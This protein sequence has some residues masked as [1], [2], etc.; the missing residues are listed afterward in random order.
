MLVENEAGVRY[1]LKRILRTHKWMEEDILQEARIFLLYSHEKYDPDR[2][3]S[4]LNYYSKILQY[5]MRRVA[6]GEARICRIKIGA[7]SR[8]LFS[9]IFSI[10]KKAF[11]EGDESECNRK[12]IAIEMGVDPEWVED[13]NVSIFLERMKYIENPDYQFN[14]EVVEEMADPTYLKELDHPECRLNSVESVK[15]M[16]EFA[17]SLKEKHADIF[18][19]RFMEDDP[20]TL[21]SIGDKYGISRE[22]VR[23]LEGKILVKF[24]E[25]CKEKEYI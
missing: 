23:Q 20:A 12:R 6:L 3:S 9:K 7:N 18:R 14:E 22:R 5:K 25:F 11:S 1:S 17:S 16:E 4:F 15:I 21:Q 2:N 13:K 8:K 19:L 24:K 10:E